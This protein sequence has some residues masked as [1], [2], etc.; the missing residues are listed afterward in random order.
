MH[1]AD[2]FGEYLL[3]ER[4]S[5]GGMAEVFL[6][7]SFGVEG[8]ER[9]LAIKRILPQMAED[10]EFINMFIDEA[11]LAVQL[12]H[13]NIGQIY[14]LGEVDNQPY[15]AME[16]IHGKDLQVIQSHFQ[17]ESQSM[18]LAQAAFIV[19]KICEALDYAH[20]KHDSFGQPL[21]IV[22]RDVS[23]PN[24]LISYEGDVKIIDFG[25][26]KAAT[27]SRRTGA[28][29]LKGKFGYMSPEQVQG[30]SLDLRSDVFV[31]GTLLH[32]LA[33]GRRLFTGV[34]DFN[35]LD[36]IR[37]AAVPLPS[38][39]NPG[40]PPEMDRVIMRAMARDPDERYPHASSFGAALRRFINLS[41]HPYS[42][43]ELSSF[44]KTVFK[45]DFQSTSVKLEKYRPL[46]PSRLSNHF[47]GEEEQERETVIFSRDRRASLQ[48]LKAAELRMGQKDNPLPEAPPH[49]EV[50]LPREP[51]EQQRLATPP[52]PAL[53]PPGNP[54]SKRPSGGRESAMEDQKV[55]ENA[56]VMESQHTKVSWRPVIILA[57]LN[58]I[59]GIVAVVLTYT[60]RV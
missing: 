58:V 5:I 17:R 7:K 50:R 34:N 46:S 18:N 44:M 56:S 35:I 29:I 55:P 21:H 39:V 25:I 52:S 20:R 10:D 27:T 24:I 32:E 47:E 15:I 38:S 42:R 40:I 16:F 41:G 8:F 6:A 49:R 4:L 28:G 60:Y 9:F 12:T 51:P 54:G 11:K 59:A 3:L 33:T 2:K 22:H 23:P 43:R 45:Q 53:A 31:A 19:S 48:H 30:K 14:E 13:P 26:A 57:V 37:D 1:K 36:D